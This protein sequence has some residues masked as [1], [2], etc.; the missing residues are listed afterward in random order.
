MFED[1]FE[2]FIC[3]LKSSFTASGIFYQCGSLNYFLFIEILCGAENL[4]KFF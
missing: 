4:K 3:F 2:M 1:G